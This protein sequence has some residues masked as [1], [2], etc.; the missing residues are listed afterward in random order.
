MGDGRG[1][2]AV[3]PKCRPGRSP[4]QAPP[5]GRLVTWI[6]VPSPI[7]NC[8]PASADSASAS[9]SPCPERV[10]S[11]W[12]RGKPMP[13]QFWRRAWA[14]A[15]W[16]RRLSGLTSPP[17]TLEACALAW[18]ASFPV[19]RANRTAR[20]ASS[21]ATPTIA[22]SSGTSSASSRSA[23]LI[24]SSVRTSRG[25]PPGNSR[26]SSRHWSGW[27][28]ALRAEYSAR[29]KPALRIPANGSSSWPGDPLVP[30]PLSRDWK[31]GIV[32]AKR[33]GEIQ[34]DTLP[35]RLGGPMNPPWGEWLMGWPIGW[36]GF[37]PLATES[38][39]WRRQM[40]SSLSTLSSPASSP[41]LALL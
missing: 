2:G 27:V 35:R 30:T 34:T 29:P 17:S 21:S 40:R 22:S 15:P 28:I 16:L 23:G 36:T 12:W 32:P 18:I 9:S 7:S 4:G 8:A 25:T 5:G 39:L 11:L 3:L 26:L 19:I 20:P 24:V 31:D 33:N 14:K 10:A 38:C 6:F 13:P 37:A 1:V 41:Q